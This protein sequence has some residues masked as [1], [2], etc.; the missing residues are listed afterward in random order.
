VFVNDLE[1]H[2]RLA[3]SDRFR[4]THLPR[5]FRIWF[6]RH[7]DRDLEGIY[8]I[9]E[10]KTDADVNGAMSEMSDTRRFP[11]DRTGL[12]YAELGHP[13]RDHLRHPLPPST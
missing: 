11:R 10:K 3:A 12:P 9:D 2:A 6:E 5:L 7:L 4:L 1:R 8:F 13:I